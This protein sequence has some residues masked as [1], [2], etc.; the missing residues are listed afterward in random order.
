MTEPSPNLQATEN[1]AV[2]PSPSPAPQKTKKP[3]RLLKYTLGAVIILLGA[4]VGGA[5]WLLNTNSGLRFAVYQLPKLA[6]VH[7]TSKTLTGS[8]LQGINA[9]ELR[10]I[11]PSAD[12]DISTLY[13]QWQPSE[14][15]QRHLHINQI[16]AGD[17]HIQSKP[18]PP[19]PKGEPM[20]E[21]DSI[22]LPMTIALDN[23]TINSITQDKRKTELVR[24]VQASYV[25][26]HKEHRLKVGSLKN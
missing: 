21:P 16:N 1:L 3:R 2:S 4:S 13:F 25:Y 5:A 10:I 15:W 23:L 18:T 17:V 9:D 14:L 19:Q 8:V 11:T 6:D 24:Q 7:I 20:S 12:I 22:S 26:D